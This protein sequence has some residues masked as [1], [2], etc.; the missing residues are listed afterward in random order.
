MNFNVVSDV[1][2]LHLIVTRA[3]ESGQPNSELEVAYGDIRD[4]WNSLCDTVNDVE[5]RLEQ[6]VVN[7]TLAKFSMKAHLIHTWLEKMITN[8]VTMRDLGETKKHQKA[9]KTAYLSLPKIDKAI[10][11]LETLHKRIEE[12]LESGEVPTDWN[13]GVNMEMVWQLRDK[14]GNEISKGTTVVSDDSEYGM[15]CWSSC[16]NE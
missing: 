16:V 2:D 1:H 13:Q 5:Q 11:K 10:E 9:N 8:I 3:I 15:S 12:F 7:P 14:L 6:Q 4:K